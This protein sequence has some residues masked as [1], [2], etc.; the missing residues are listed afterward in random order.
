MKQLAA[1]IFGLSILSLCAAERLRLILPEKIYAMP[2]VECNI[3]FA[4]L[5]DVV[6]P[7]NYFFEVRAPK[8]R[9]DTGRWRFTPTEKDCGEFE[10]RLNVYDDA[11]LAGTGKTRIVVMPKAGKNEKTLLLIGSSE[12]AA[13]IYPARILELMKDSGITLTGTVRRADYAPG[14]VTE[15]Y[16]GWSYAMFTRNAGSPFVREGKLDFKQYIDRKCNGKAPD[17]ITITLGGNDAFGMGY[18]ASEEK[19]A[20]ILGNAEKLISELRRSAPEAIIGVGLTYQG[21]GQDAFGAN[22]GC[23]LSARQF[24]INHRM[25]IEGLM[26]KFENT[27]DNRLSVIPIY[28]NI[29]GEHNFPTVSEPAS[30]GNSLR[31]VRQSNARHPAPA[32]YRQIGDA[33][34]AWINAKIIETK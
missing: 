23:L 20:A 9:N 31:V 30:Q 4:S 16:G 32:G 5:A 18:N 24:R 25:L 26:K 12:T 33:M 34:S 8:G 28:L 29:D 13:G 6:N 22:Y 10:L 17:I 14:V 27:G 1:L 15:G 19:L 3:Y 2:G 11:G 7:A 21:A